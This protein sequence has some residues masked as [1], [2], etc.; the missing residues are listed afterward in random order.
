M[1]P[2]RKGHVALLQGVVLFVAHGVVF[3]QLE[4]RLNGVDQRGGFNGL[5]EKFVRAAFN[6]AHRHRDSAVA[7]EK[8]NRDVAP[9]V[10]EGVRY[11]KT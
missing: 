4:R 11:V 8:N 9:A 3:R 6:G 5:G 7:G 2:W 1:F 10:L